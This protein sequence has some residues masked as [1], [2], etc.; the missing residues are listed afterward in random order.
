[1]APQ[2]EI[3]IPNTT[4]SGSSKP[5]T[6]YNVSL[7]LPLRSFTVQK[8]YSDFVVLHSGLTDQVG[9]PPP[10]ALPAKSWFQKTVSNP[11]LTEER[12]RGLETYLK[13][14]NEIDDSRWR[15]TSV[16]RAFLNLPSSFASQTSSKAGALHSVISGPGGGGA[17]IT[18][19]VIWLDVHRDLKAQLQ[20][21][22]LNLTNRD[23]ASTPQKQH[24]ASAAAKSHLVKA[25]SLIA[26]LE[27]GLTNIQTATDGGGWGGQKLG[28]GEIRR[29]KD[30]I[31]SAKRDKD[32]L[33]NLLNA[34]ATKSKLDSAVASMQETQHLM[35][36]GTNKPKVGGG[37][38][39]GK[40]TAETRELDNQGV[41]QLQKQK[42]ADQDRDVE[43]LRRIVQRQKELG[44]VINQ[45]L[46]VQNEML[47]MVDEDVDRVHGK[48]QIA[49]RRVGKI[50]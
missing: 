41:L 39:L 8:R 1:M 40:E 49:K 12:R 20:D 25:G 27:E 37:R 36:N 38:V 13:T 9:S 3:S 18:D 45:E 11:Q 30:L 22:R 21:A 44:I 34:M 33:E 35:G 29:R 48:I 23:Q 16:W 31:A 47:R 10:C 32:G 43:E 42:M 50:S 15:S 46:E 14:I 26:A 28:E 6:I 2:V 19:P 5:Y 4:I 24:E 17:P 7:R